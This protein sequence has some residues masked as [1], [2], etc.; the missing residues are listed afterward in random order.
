MSGLS[1]FSK[2]IVLIFRLYQKSAGGKFYS[3]IYFEKEGNL[4]LKWCL[5]L[6]VTCLIQV[7]ASFL[8]KLSRVPNLRLAENRLSIFPSNIKNVFHYRIPSR[9]KITQ[10][11]GMPTLSA[12]SQSNPSVKENFLEV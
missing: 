10:R 9:E 2:L 3:F 6:D 1:R 12:S 11:I 5:G 4:L 7:A 8:G